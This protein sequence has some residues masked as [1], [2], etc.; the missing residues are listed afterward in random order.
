MLCVWRSEGECVAECQDCC[1]GTDG[2]IRT[3]VSWDVVHGGCSLSVSA[4]RGIYR[5][6]VRVASSPVRLWIE[7]HNDTKSRP[8]ENARSGGQVLR[9]GRVS[10]LVLQGDGAGGSGEG[11][12]VRACG[13]KEKEPRE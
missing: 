3:K 12:S 7:G 8:N 13:S 9:S 4:W 11:A 2:R 6:Q 10:G 5:R 1:L